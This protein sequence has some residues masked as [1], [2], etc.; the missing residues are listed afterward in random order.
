MDKA[1]YLRAIYLEKEF[2]NAYGTYSLRTGLFQKSFGKFYDK[3]ITIVK[4]I[5]NF[6]RFSIF[7]VVLKMENFTQFAIIFYFSKLVI[8]YNK[9]GFGNAH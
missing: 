5:V 7:E 6:V 9:D 1:I 3:W 4:F 8:V 2:I